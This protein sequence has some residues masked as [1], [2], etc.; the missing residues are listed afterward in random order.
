MTTFDK[1]NRMQAAALQEGLIMTHMG[2]DSR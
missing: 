2:M 1:I